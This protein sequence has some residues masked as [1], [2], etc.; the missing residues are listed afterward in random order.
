MKLPVT[1]GVPLIC[2]VEELIA[3]L[4]GKEQFKETL[5]KP[6]PQGTQTS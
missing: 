2:P 5:V 3:M 1:V 4:G 6:K